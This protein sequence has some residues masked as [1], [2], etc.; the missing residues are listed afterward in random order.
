MVK[1]ILK[2]LYRRI[3]GQKFMAM[4]EIATVPSS[5]WIEVER[6][7]C[8]WRLNM[9]SCISREI[10]RAG[11]WEP[12]TTKLIMDS[13]HE[14]MHVLDIGANFGYYTLCLAHLVGPSG[15]VWA[16]EPVKRFRDQLEWH[17]RKN[18]FMDRVTVV[19][20][21]LSDKSSEMEIVGDSSSATLHPTVS[22][23]DDRSEQISLRA[24]DQVSSALGIAKVDFIKLDIDGHEPRFFR[25]AWKTLLRFHPPIALEF[26]QH[27][28][29]V[30][31][32]D[33]REQARLLHELGYTIC[34][35]TSR[36]PFVSEMEFLMACGNF[37]HS[38]NALALPFA[39]GETSVQ[40]WGRG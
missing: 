6:L 21:G 23:P 13:V 35:E 5:G 22:T 34:N 12:D 9:E 2:G 38:G 28:L 4:T 40:K 1:R 19:P 27:C 18:G 24:L 39:A 20:H 3:R 36:K 30:A 31:G 25:G 32:S 10:V 29:H 8:Q 37:D 14:G 7:E 15:H 33:V 26:A 17:I 11:V 16:F